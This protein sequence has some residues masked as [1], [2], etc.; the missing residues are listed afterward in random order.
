MKKYAD[1]KGNTVSFDCAGCDIVGG[2]YKVGNIITTSHFD[3]HQDFLVPIPGFVIIVS[4]RHIKSIDEFTKEEEK[5]FIALVMKIRKAMRSKLNIE[6][7]YIFQSEDTSHH[8]HLW[9]FP[10]YDWMEKLGK[11]IESVRPIMNYAKKEMRSKD[12]I[13]NIEKSIKLLKEAF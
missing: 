7:V 10:R 13:R 8:F 5:E 2:K 1:W 11:Q 4:K 3:V 12:N 6:N 9:M